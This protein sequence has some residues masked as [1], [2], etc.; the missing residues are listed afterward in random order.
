MRKDPIYSR[1][2]LAKN[3]ELLACVDETRYEHKESVM[4]DISVIYIG[5][6]SLFFL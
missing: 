5:L 3:T 1:D 2:N 4:S 6:I